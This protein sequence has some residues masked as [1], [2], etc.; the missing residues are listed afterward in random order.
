MSMAEVDKARL[1]VSGL[2][3]VVLGLGLRNLGCRAEGLVFC[4]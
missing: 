1:R 4:L 2:S 3:F